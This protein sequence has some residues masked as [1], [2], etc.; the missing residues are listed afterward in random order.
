MKTVA[1][2][3]AGKEFFSTV[4]SFSFLSSIVATA[5]LAAA[6]GMLLRAIS[7]A[8]SGERASRMVE[9]I[10]LSSP[11]LAAVV[12]CGAMSRCRA[13]G[14]LETL[15]AAP[16]TDAEVV[17]GKF[18]A[19]FGLCLAGSVSIAA[20][21]MVSSDLAGFAPLAGA[22][23][24]LGG[25]GL[26]AIASAQAFWCAAGLFFALLFRRESGAI[27]STLALAVVTAA[28]SSGDLPVSSPGDL[29]SRFDLVEFSLGI[30]DSRPLFAFVS[31]TAFFLFA[32]VR[33]LES[34][35]WLLRSNR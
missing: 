28:V 3:I 26:A 32:A 13:D 17:V 7:P 19:A 20:I 25:A 5:A 6:V 30:G 4:R 33:L 27:A 21:W 9:S 18:L 23:L 31:A 14:S 22:E 1:P 8:A 10:L 12:S 11:L 24:A 16:V 34:R 15:L 29:L 2:T 35:A